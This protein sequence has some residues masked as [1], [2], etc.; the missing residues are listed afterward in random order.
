MTFP[1]S[2]KI[3]ERGYGIEFAYSRIANVESYSE[4]RH[5]AIALLKN[6]TDDNYY[7]KYYICKWKESSTRAED[8]ILLPCKRKAILLAKRANKVYPNHVQRLNGFDGYLCYFYQRRQKVYSW[9]VACPDKWVDMENVVKELINEIPY[10]SP[11][12]KAHFITVS[13]ELSGKI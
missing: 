2:D 3:Q 12:H 11:L 5:F 8:R 4:D 10:P 7:L 9:W 13:Q 6:R 1:F